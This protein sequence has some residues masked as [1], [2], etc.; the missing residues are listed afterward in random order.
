MAI[1]VISQQFQVGFGCCKN[2]VVSTQLIQPASLPEMM[3][4]AKI[5]PFVPYLIHVNFNFENVKETI[6]DKIRFIKAIWIYES[7]IDRKSI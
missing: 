3:W 6:K 5:F 4:L 7:S 2:K 1:L